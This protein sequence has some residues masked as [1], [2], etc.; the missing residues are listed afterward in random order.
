MRYHCT[1][2]GGTL[3]DYKVNQK[4]PFG[5]LQ[6]IVCNS[7][8]SGGITVGAVVILRYTFTGIAQIDKN[9]VLA[10]F[11]TRINIFYFNAPLKL[12]LLI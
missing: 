7:G 8:S 11:Q 1:E 5:V 6:Y 2:P 4:F 9:D 10:R 12:L 3:S